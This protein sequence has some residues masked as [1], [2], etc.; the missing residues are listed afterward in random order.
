MQVR[1]P[2]INRATSFVDA[3]RE[4]EYDQEIQGVQ[5]S[6]DQF[7][8]GLRAGGESLAVR[9]VGSST[10]VH[11]VDNPSLGPDGVAQFAIQCHI[12][13]GDDGAT[14]FT[15]LDIWTRETRLADV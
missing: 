5:A 4:L 3:M 9:R 2:T 7:V 12:R 13:Q 1:G 15:L 10:Y 8:E 6:V 14:I 11:C